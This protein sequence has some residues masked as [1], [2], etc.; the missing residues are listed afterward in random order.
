MTKRQFFVLI[1]TSIFL[2]GFYGWATAFEIVL[3]REIKITENLKEDFDKAVGE[4]VKQLGEGGCKLIR[5]F[6]YTTPD[7]PNILTITARCAEEGA[8]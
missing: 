6:A 4:M 7:K 8:K 5:G 1:F 2:F 3:T